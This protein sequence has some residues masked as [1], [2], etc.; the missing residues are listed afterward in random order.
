MTVSKGLKRL[1]RYFETHDTYENQFKALEDVQGFEESNEDFLFG[2][3]SFKTKV[4]FTIIRHLGPMCSMRTN[5]RA[6]QARRR[7]VFLTRLFLVDI[8][9]SREYRRLY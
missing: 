2:K 8:R 1:V 9:D 7:S 5:G 4:S 6:N 3:E